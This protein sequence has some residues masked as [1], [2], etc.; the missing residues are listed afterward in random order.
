MKYFFKEKEG[1]EQVKEEG[2]EE[3][4]KGRREGEGREEQ[5]C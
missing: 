3:E 5:I 2:E 1:K 4:G